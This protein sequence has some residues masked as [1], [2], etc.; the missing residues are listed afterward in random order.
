MKSTEDLRLGKQYLKIRSYDK[1]LE[2][3]TKA[4]IQGDRAAVS[5]LYK[6]GVHFFDEKEYRKAEQAFQLLAG[7]GHAESCIYLGK[8]SEYGDTGRKDI[9]A[10]FGYYAE[11]YR[12]GLPRGAY[13][14]GKLMMPDAL[15]SEE[16]RDIAVNW[17]M[18]AAEGNLYQSY[19]KL[20]QLYSVGAYDRFA[21][22]SL[23][24]DKKALS[25]Y[26]QGAMRGDGE[27][28]ERAGLAFLHGFGT[29]INVKRAAIL[30]RQAA[31]HGRATACMR[32]GHLYDLGMGVYR[33]MKQ[34]VYWYMEAYRRGIERGKAEA[35]QVYLHA[36]VS[37]LRSARSKKGK[38]RAVEYLEEA[39]S[40]GCLEAYRVLAETSYVDGDQEKRLYYLRKGAE[41]GSEECR[42]DLISYYT[43]QAMP[44]MRSVSRLSG[45]AHRNKEDKELWNIYI[46]QLK[47]AEELY[48]KAAEAGDADSWAVLARMYLY[49]GPEVGAGKQEFLEAAEKGENSKRIDTRKLR[50][51]FYAGEKPTDGEL[52]H[53]ENPKEAFRCAKELASKRH[54]SFY[55]ILADYY[56]KGYGIK[57]NPEKA[58]FW[59]SKFKR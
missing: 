41:A 36:G 4:V 43:M 26:L 19:A 48:K 58:E 34:S 53:E 45:Q 10:A 14:A 57:A 6:L 46:A 23:R 15:R 30:F 31:D 5:L 59:R 11:A 17:F 22:T 33:D 52:L 39:G 3:L 29:E 40:L 27:C 56:Q 12:L 38:E 7:R 24:D 16:V 28:M 21:V 50:W 35:A 20:G 47:K 42:K 18:A 49:K 55:P 25:Y 2:H 32:L 13:K 51:R 37:S 54:G 9:Q 1:A 44:V 8:I